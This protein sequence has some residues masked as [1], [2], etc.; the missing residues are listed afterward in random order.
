[1]SEERRRYEDEGSPL[2]EPDFVSEGGLIRSHRD[3]KV[4][5]HGFKLATQIFQLSKEFPVEERYSLT[6]QVR[7]SSR[8]VTSSIAESWRKRRYVAAFVSKLNDAEAEAAETQTWLEYAVT[9]EYLDERTGNILMAE[10]DRLIG[11]LVKMQNDADSWVSSIRKS[12][13]S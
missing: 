7:R 10:Y 3:L 8:S 11:A 13:G 4:Y 2:A 6:D 12:S 1:M 9:C 5:Q